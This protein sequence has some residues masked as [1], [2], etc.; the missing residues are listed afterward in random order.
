MRF[1]EFFQRRDGV[2]RFE[3][4]FSGAH[5]GLGG[6]PRLRVRD[7][8]IAADTLTP[9]PLTAVYGVFCFITHDGM[10]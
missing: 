2:T 3:A 10:N 9:A 8:H 7:R 1:F 4:T 5:A 6:V